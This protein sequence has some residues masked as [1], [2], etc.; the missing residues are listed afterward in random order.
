MTKTTQLAELSDLICGEKV[1]INLGIAKLVEFAL[2][3]GE[4]VLA[5]NGGLNCL[6]GSRTGRSPKDRSSSKTP[7]PVT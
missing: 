1:H 7:Q 3:R 4:G 2:Q 6:T 5:D